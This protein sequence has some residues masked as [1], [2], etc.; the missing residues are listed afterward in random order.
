LE[1]EPMATTRKT[2]RRRE[3]RREPEPREHWK[4]PPTG[5]LLAFGGLIALVYLVTDLRWGTVIL[6]PMIVGTL[7]ALG[8]WLPGAPRWLR[9]VGRWAGPLPMKLVIF[10]GLGVVAW[11]GVTGAKTDAAARD[12]AEQ[13]RPPPRP[14][15]PA[16]A[17]EPQWAPTLPSEVVVAEGEHI[18]AHSRAKLESFLAL[19][20]LP[21]DKRLL[22]ELKMTEDPAM[23]WTV[24]GTKVTGRVDSSSPIVEVRER[25]TGNTFW[26]T[27]SALVP[28]K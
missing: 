21:E 2:K 11:I 17:P 25:E 1:D 13:I 12:L 19:E 9:A 16:G 28:A 15:L 20:R 24:P 18:A 14:D 8:I 23:L 3:E 10:A 26:T 7:L 6:A 22:A 5:V 4:A 27:R